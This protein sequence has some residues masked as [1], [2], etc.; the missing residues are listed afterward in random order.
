MTIETRE[1]SLILPIKDTARA[2][3]RLDLPRIERRQIAMALAR[4]ALEVATQCLPACQI[5][6][7]TSDHEVRELAGGLGAC[8]IAD[9][10]RGLNQAI[11]CGMKEAACRDPRRGVV[12]LVCDLPEVNAS[13]LNAFF[14]M[15]ESSAAE[16]MYVADRSGHGTTAVSCPP[17]VA[18]RMVFGQDSAARFAALGF[19][20]AANAPRELRSDLDTLNDLDALPTEVR[21]SWFQ[22]AVA[23]TPTH[24]NSGEKCDG[25]R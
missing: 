1:L 23:T 7:V 24:P 11:E 13:A 15:I 25:F 12:V 19:R 10:G 9:P 17:G 8:V 6:V 5:Y 4:H 2:K 18:V 3:S 20:L 16:A 22:S 21:L 14:R